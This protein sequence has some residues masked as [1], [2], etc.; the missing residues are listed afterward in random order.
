M[1]NS[2]WI[3]FKI[4]KVYQRINVIFSYSTSVAMAMVVAI[5][6]YTFILTKPVPTS[7]LQPSVYLAHGMFE[8]SYYRQKSVAREYAFITSKMDIDLRD[9]WNW[10]TKMLFVYILL[11]YQ[12]KKNVC[13]CTYIE[14]KWN[15]YLGSNYSIEGWFKYSWN[16]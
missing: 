10:N 12:T 2:K 1:Y 8:Q 5:S 3:Q 9:V 6:L 7:E 11:E 13:L 16:H 15:Y 4:N 14:C